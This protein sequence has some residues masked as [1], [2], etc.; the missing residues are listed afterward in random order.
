MTTQEE[1]GILTWNIGYF[2]SMNDTV[3]Y[4]L[5]HLQRLKE[6]LDHY[7]MHP[8]TKDIDCEIDEMDIFSSFPIG[9]WAIYENNDTG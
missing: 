4:A 7:W 9:N 3:T 2:I 1:G 6:N 5:E 8:K